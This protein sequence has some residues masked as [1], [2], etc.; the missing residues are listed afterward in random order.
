MELLAQAEPPVGLYVGLGIAF[1]L[2]L[3]VAGTFNGLVRLRQHVR[4]SWHGIDV[5]LKRRYDLIPNL[6]AAVKGYAAHERDL[7]E[8]LAAARTRAQANR[9]PVASQVEDERPLIAGLRQLLALAERYPEL[10]AD[11]NFLA[12]QEELADTEDRIAAAR[13]FYNGNVRD[14]NTRRESFPSSLLARLFS[15]KGESYWEIEEASQ[16]AR[17]EVGLS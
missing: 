7:L 6:V 16:R 15:F 12:L 17:P 3:W 2:L 8:G 1:V 14:Y 13:R 5:Q 4:E 11:R 9:G 10:K